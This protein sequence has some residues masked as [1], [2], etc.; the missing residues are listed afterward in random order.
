MS[1]QDLGLRGPLL[2]PSSGPM[3]TSCHGK[4]G[5]HYNVYRLSND[6][7]GMSALRELFPHGNADE[8][9]FVL[10]STSGIH[11]SYETIEDAESICTGE[12]IPITFLV[13]QPRIVSMRYGSALPIC[14]DDF[15]FLRRLRESSCHAA[16]AIG[17]AP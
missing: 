1:E 10:F 5:A 4:A 15:A 13:I 2:E 16:S 7:L 14:A 6:D 12:R 8:L 9:N 3:W 11:G 17:K